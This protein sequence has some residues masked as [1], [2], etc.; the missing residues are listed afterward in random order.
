VAWVD[1]ADGR[2]KR[3]R[4]HSAP[5]LAQ[6]KGWLDEQE[7][8]ALPRSP[9]GEAMRYA[10]NQWTTLNRYVQDGE[11][12]S[13][14]NACERAIRGVAIGRKN[15]LFVGSEFGGETAATF[16]SLI[17]SARLHEVEPWAYLRDVIRLMPAIDPADTTRLTELLPHRWRLAHP[18][19]HVPL[20]R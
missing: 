5:V 14:N 12:E 8:R 20:N 17:G 10:L 2:L 4:E 9:M 7:P 13:D 6:F 11:L 19:A 1:H 16:F 15:W 3:R 18:E